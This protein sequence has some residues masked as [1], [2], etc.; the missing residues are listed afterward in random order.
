[1]NAYT[2]LSFPAHQASL[3]YHKTAHCRPESQLIFPNQAMPPK[4]LIQ[5]SSAIMPPRAEQN[6]QER[7]EHKDYDTFLAIL[8]MADTNHF[9]CYPFVLLISS[10]S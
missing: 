2:S 6:K 7:I 3:L 9:K 1:M 4:N 5:L 8:K 10:E